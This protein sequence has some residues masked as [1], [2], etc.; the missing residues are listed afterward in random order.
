MRIY[1]SNYSS[2][3]ICFKCQYDITLEVL[4]IIRFDELVEEYQKD[5]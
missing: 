4:D 5:F 3:C 1:I 2:D